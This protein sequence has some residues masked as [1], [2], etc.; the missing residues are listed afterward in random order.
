M[1]NIL[2]DKIELKGE[3]NEVFIFKFKKIIY[4][5]N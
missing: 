2:E 5:I 1:I 4:F 3:E